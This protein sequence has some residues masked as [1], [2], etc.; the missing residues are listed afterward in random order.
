M[1]MTRR[2]ELLI[3]GVLL[4]A[5]VGSLAI[6]TL[7]ARQALQW[8]HAGPTGGDAAAIASSRQTAGLRYAADAEGAAALA[9]Q[10]ALALAG[11]THAAALSQV[12]LLPD[13]L[14]HRLVAD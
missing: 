1:T 10:P 14:R 11:M 12:R 4:L 3:A 8:Q 2:I 9:P 13:D 6:H 7:S 5:L